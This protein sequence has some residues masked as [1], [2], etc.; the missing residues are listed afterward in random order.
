MRTI[1]SCRAVFF[2][3]L[4]AATPLLAQ[5]RCKPGDTIK[6]CLDRYSRDTYVQ[7]MTAQ[8]EDAFESQPTG[9]DSGGTDLASNSKDFSPLMALSALLGHGTED[10]TGKVIYDLNFLLPALANPGAMNAQLEAVVT[11]QP[12]ISELIRNHLHARNRDAE[13]EPLKQKLGELADYTIRFSYNHTSDSLG[14]SF[15]QHEENYEDLCRTALDMADWAAEDTSLKAGMDLAGLPQDKPFE[16]MLPS[17]EIKARQQF[18]ALDRELAARVSDVMSAAGLKSYHQLVD[19]QPQ[20]HVTAERKLRDPLAGADEISVNVTYEGSWRNLNRA[21]E[22]CAGEWG[23]E[24]CVEKYMEYVETWEEAIEKG[25]RFSFSGEYVDI[26]GETINTGLSNLAPIVSESARKLVLKAGWGRDF[27]FG[28]G[29]P[30]K[31]DLVGSYEDISDDPKRQDRGIARLT[32]TRNVGKMSIPFGIVYANH[33]EFL[34][35]EGV[36]AR[37]SAHIGLTFKMQDGSGNQ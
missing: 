35:A 32:L 9:V 25:Y 20:F 33:G 7:E 29:E 14:R 21:T 19:N 2:L 8:E 15:A 4:L 3:M 6:T 28:D 13:V 26:E 23:S 17:E 34:D 27:N 1:R 18:S 24:E 12:Q 11:M 22:G 30:I 10:G 31:L 16:E 37:L 36:D 5:E